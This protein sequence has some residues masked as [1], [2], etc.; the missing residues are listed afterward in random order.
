MEIPTVVK[1]IFGIVFLIYISYKLLK[2]FGPN[3]S[4]LQEEIGSAKVE[5]VYKPS[6]MVLSS[7]LKGLSFSTSFWIF[8]KDWNYR[9]LMDKVIFM[10]GSTD[11][12]GGTIGL[13]CGL[14]ESM[15]DLYVSMPVYGSTAPEKI[16][17]EDLP[18]QKWIHVCIVLENRTLDL[19][20]NGRLYNSKH[21]PNLPKIKEKE[22][23]TFCPDGGFSGYISRV[24]HYP[25]ALGKGAVISLYKS[26]PVN[27]NKL[28]QLLKYISDKLGLDKYANM[29]LSI[30]IEGGV[31]E[32][33]DE[34]EEEAEGFK[35]YIN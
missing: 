29:K 32:G 14:G 22:K 2:W 33:D 7:P 5:K 30:K 19:W 9:Y 20:L 25:Y 23:V 12:I 21:L 15:N 26:G 11:V 34:A 17:Y 24:Y 28:A 27:R 8:L 31:N 6:Q 10:K 4:I 18:L 13:K 3:R 1:V 35:N 16:S